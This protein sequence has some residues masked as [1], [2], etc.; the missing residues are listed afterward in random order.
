MNRRR[1]ADDQPLN[2]ADLLDRFPLTAEERDA[3]FRSET[4]ARLEVVRLLVVSA[5]FFNAIG[6][7]EYGGRHGAVRDR[8]LVEQVVGAA[9]QTYG[10]VDPHPTSFD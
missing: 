6:I 7:V 3:F 1:V 10:G 8:R 9:F 4:A 5:Y 2:L